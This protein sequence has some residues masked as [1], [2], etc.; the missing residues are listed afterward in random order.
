MSY[1]S[2]VPQLGDQQ[3]YGRVLMLLRTHT[4]N[5]TA[6]NVLQTNNYSLCTYYFYLHANVSNFTTLL[7]DFFV[8][9]INLLVLLY[10]TIIFL[11]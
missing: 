8:G 10:N 3:H 5:K 6:R 9:C 1:D 2:M 4:V 11:L 7:N